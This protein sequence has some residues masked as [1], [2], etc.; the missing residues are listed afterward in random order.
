M[1][2]VPPSVSPVIMVPLTDFVLALSNVAP[3]TDFK[4]LGTSHARHE[5]SSLPVGY[6][7]VATSSVSVRSSIPLPCHAPPGCGDIRCLLTT[8]LLSPPVT[9]TAPGCSHDSIDLVE[10]ASGDKVCTTRVRTGG[11]GRTSPV[12]AVP[13]SVPERSDRSSLWCTLPLEVYPG[14][15]RCAIYV[16][17]LAYFPVGFPSASTTVR[18]FMSTVLSFGSPTGDMGV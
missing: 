16:A 8:S 14:C 5:A 11:V 12:A 4:V 7:D 13:H 1:P 3:V 17:S 6:I 18:V 15:A 10:T 9:R 2:T